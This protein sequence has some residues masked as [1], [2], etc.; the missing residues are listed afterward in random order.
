MQAA[1]KRTARISAC[2]AFRY[3]LARKW[4]ED[5]SLVFVML[6][7]STADAAV[8]DPT[9]RRCMGFAQRD[10][11]DGIQVVNLYAYR[12]TDPKALR[13]CPDPI[14]PENNRFLHLLLA[15]QA[16]HGTPVV[17]AWGA[18]ADADRVEEV[19]T[20]VPSVKWRCLGLT[21]A[22]APRHPLYVRGDQPLTPF[23]TARALSAD[24][25]TS[26]T[27]QVGRPVST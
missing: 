1:L 14:G 6:N 5:P 27:V 7:P 16:R 15:E 13:A 8:D 26:T 12:A 21:K 25:A 11:F 24:P 22:G 23:A 20:M 18:L 2:S 4:G 19:L 3:S 9:I 17:A 10:G